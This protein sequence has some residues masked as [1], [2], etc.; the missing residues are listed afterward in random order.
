MCSVR[1]RFLYFLALVALFAIA[2]GCADEAK[3]DTPVETFKAYVKAIK[4]K[5]TTEM[6]SLLSSES[7]KMHQDEA[8]A[9]NVTLDD[10]VK[11]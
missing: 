11:R 1:L 5:D 2:S 8:K 4:E 10:I 7:I 6:K 3:P 9:Q